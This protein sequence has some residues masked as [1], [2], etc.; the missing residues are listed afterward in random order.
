MGKEDKTRDKF[1]KKLTSI[2]GAD[3][4]KEHLEVDM[5]VGQRR[6]GDL[7]EASSWITTYC[8][9]QWETGS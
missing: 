7:I 8:S 5:E 9:E 6:A 4:R 2:E 1:P 3:Q